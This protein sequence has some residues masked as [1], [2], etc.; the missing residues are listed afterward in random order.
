MLAADGI[1]TLLHSL[2]WLNGI[3][4]TTFWEKPQ[5]KVKDI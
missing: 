4:R 5:Q 1:L 3:G 2:G